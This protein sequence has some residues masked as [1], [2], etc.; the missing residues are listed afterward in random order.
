MWW[1]TRGCSG[2]GRSG[3][4]GLRGVGSD[5]LDDTLRRDL[6]VIDR[7]SARLTSLVDELLDLAQLDTGQAP[8]TPVPLQRPT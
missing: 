7:T 3:A 6:T 5:P 1:S 2:G 4:C 8:I